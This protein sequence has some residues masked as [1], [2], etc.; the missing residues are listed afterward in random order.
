MTQKIH[1]EVLS[2]SDSTWSEESDLFFSLHLCSP[3]HRLSPKFILLETDETMFLICR[4]E[5]F[6]SSKKLL[7][8][9][10]KNAT[11]KELQPHIIVSEKGWIKTSE[12]FYFNDSEEP[13]RNIRKIIKVYGDA[14]DP[15][16]AQAANIRRSSCM[17]R[18][19]A[20]LKN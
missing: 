2:T 5:N 7:V 18:F 13:I 14:F 19:R 20:L 16:L 3:S 4:N 10:A 8:V 1:P 12:P 9:E 11:V 17:S 6:S 15:A